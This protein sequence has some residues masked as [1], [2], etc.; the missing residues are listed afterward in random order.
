MSELLKGITGHQVAEQLTKVNRKD[1]DRFRNTLNDDRTCAFDVQLSI[2]TKFDSQYFQLKYLK[3][4][5]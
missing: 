1:E 5:F 4:V 2:R 3:S